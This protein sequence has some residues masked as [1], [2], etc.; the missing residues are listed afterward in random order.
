MEKKYSF[1]SESQTGLFLRLL[2]IL[3][4][5]SSYV[6]HILH[7]SLIMIIHKNHGLSRKNRTSACKTR[8][9]KK[10][11]TQVLRDTRKSSPADASLNLNPI[12]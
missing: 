7:N 9:S 3:V 8:V 6:C 1:P 12:S 11:D 5:L 10:R 4:N 2:Y